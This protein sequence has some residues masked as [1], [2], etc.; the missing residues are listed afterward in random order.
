MAEIIIGNVHCSHIL[1]RGQSFR[2]QSS[3]KPTSSSV[4]NATVSNVAETM[5]DSG[6]DQVD[7]A[8]NFEKRLQYAMQQSL[9]LQEKQLK[10]IEILQEELGEKATGMP[11]RIV[12]SNKK[13]VIEKFRKP[14]KGILKKTVSR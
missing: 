1:E 3:H 5:P 12:T 11:K 4:A 9:I 6:K 7:S 13:V 2:E 10:D 8:Y 14:L